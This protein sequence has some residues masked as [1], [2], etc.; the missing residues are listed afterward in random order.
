MK[1]KSMHHSQ[2]I[3][4]VGL[5][6]MGGRVGENLRDR[7]YS[8]AG[9]DISEQVRDQFNKLSKHEVNSLVALRTCLKSPCVIMIFLPAGQSVDDTMTTLLPSMQKGDL[10][11]DCGNSYYKDAERRAAFLE[12]HGIDF[13]DVGVSGGLSGARNGACLTVGGKK[14]L[15]DKHEHLFKAMAVENGYLYVGQTGCGHLV[16]T[17]H[18]GIEYGFLQAISEGLNVIKTM[19]DN[20]QL[21]IDIAKLCEVWCNG[22]IIES[23]LMHDAANAMKMLHND[24]SITDTIGGGETGTWAKQMADESG[25]DV[26]VLDAALKSRKESRNRQSFTGKIIAAIRNV[27][28]GHELFT[29]K[30]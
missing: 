19:S 10:L 12:P 26:P 30:S 16:K 17:V 22:S 9:F 23:R 1:N 7:D 24:P 11:I 14:E 5:G 8:V 13:M 28:G 15:F 25:V 29:S 3:G 20:K 27:F 4:I 21:S 2:E 18:N 6:R